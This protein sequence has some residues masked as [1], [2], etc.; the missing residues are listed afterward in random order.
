MDIKYDLITKLE[1]P[2]VAIFADIIK[3]ITIFIKT[4]FEDPKH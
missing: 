2:R 4:V 3:I 1:M